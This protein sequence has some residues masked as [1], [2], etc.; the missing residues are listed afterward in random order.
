MHQNAESARAERERV[1]VELADGGIGT[2]EVMAAKGAAR[3]HER[4]TR[5]HEAGLGH[6]PVQRNKCA[7]VRGRDFVNL[8]ARKWR[9]P[10]HALADA[11]PGGV[12]L[13][14]SARD[15]L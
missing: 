12:V 14:V 2:E 1:H 13:T 10:S 8:L 4:V 6:G 9:I 11:N 3:D 5:H 15:E 7:R